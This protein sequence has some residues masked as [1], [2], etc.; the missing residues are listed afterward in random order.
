MIRVTFKDNSNSIVCDNANVCHKK[1]QINFFI[2]SDLIW[3]TTIDNIDEF[4]L[5]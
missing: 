2:G 1:N 3:Y 4:Y 5:E